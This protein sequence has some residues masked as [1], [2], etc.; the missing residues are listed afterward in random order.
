MSL[1]LRQI[2]CALSCAAAISRNLT[3]RAAAKSRRSCILVSRQAQ[4]TIRICPVTKI[5]EAL[6]LRPLT[7]AKAKAFDFPVDIGA[8]LRPIVLV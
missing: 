2:L 4:T 3:V 1:K 8:G 7:V 6:A 5:N